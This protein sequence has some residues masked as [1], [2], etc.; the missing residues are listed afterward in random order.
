MMHTGLHDIL[1][2]ES[3]PETFLKHLLSILQAEADL[4]AIKASPSLLKVLIIDINEARAEIIAQ[5]LHAT[6][7][8]AE[9]FTTGLDAFTLFLKGA[10]IPRIIL[11]DQEHLPDPLFLQRLVQRT[12]Q[13]YGFKVPLLRLVS[14][15]IPDTPLLPRQTSQSLPEIAP[16]EASPTTTIEQLQR[17]K[18]N[19]TGKSTGRYQI[20]TLLG[21]GLQGNVYQAYDRLREQEIALKAMQVSSMPYALARTS[22]EDVNL[23]QQEV[24]LLSS[25]D[26]PHIQIP[27][28]TG[29]SYISGASFVFKTMPYYPE[30]SL[31]L[32]L[33][34]RTHKTFSPH[35]IVPLIVQLA[36]ALQHAHN[37]QILF[38]NF[39]LSNLL[40]RNQTD[41]I[42]KL[43]S[44]LSDFPVTQDGS[45]FSK[46]LDAFPYMAPERWH[47]QA[48]AASD[49][50]ALACIAYE[51]L[52]G[53]PPFQGQSEYTMRFLHL[54]MRP[55]PPIASN[56]TMPLAI[57]RVILQGMAKRPEERFSSISAFASAL[58]RY[59][60]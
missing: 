50:Y 7:Y 12:L 52:A 28:N 3:Q 40:I 38:Q 6:G 21:N 27:L 11:V 26:H 42:R 53:R 1:F 33:S 25:L 45:F 14:P 57:N 16:I 31:A 19:L 30:R 55:Q 59:C 2:S 29:R 41:D 22:E 9:T 4:S 18:I 32:W 46:T 60:S 20:V 44:V 58:Q 24:E 36:D 43:D 8:K 13:L 34:R 23:F 10:Y 49:Q 15:A 37:H 54:N 51:L 48:L 35:E 17:E 39:K 47:G 56:T 5:L